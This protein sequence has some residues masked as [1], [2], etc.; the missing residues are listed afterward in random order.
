[1]RE[2]RCPAA[3]ANCAAH[4]SLRH[5]IDEL[6]GHI[7]DGKLTI[8]DLVKVEQTLGA[9]IRNHICTVDIQ[10]RDCVAFGT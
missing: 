6:R 4:N 5:Q 1:M 7:K 10:L 3:A 2:Y 9:W 8:M